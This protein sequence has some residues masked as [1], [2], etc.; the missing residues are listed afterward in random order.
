M[1]IS[2]RVKLDTSVLYQKMSGEWYKISQGRSTHIEQSSDA[3]VEQGDI[4]L[5][6][7]QNAKN[8]KKTN[9]Q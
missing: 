1:E 8:L 3:G 5:K 4:S 9:Q 6:I 2:I 7:C